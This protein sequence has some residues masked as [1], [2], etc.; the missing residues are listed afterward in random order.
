MQLDKFLI[1]LIIVSVF[2]AF[3]GG[4]YI[5]MADAYSVT[6]EEKYSTAFSNFNETFEITEDISDNMKE[7]SVEQDSSDWNFGKTVMAALGA[8][9]SIFTKGIPTAISMIGNIT[10]FL[11]VPTFI[12][13]ALQTIVIICVSFALIYLYFRYQNK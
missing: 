12:V 2:A 4:I 11:P 6:V 1:S 10:T 9:K 7:A 13:S 8:V 3:F 5:Y